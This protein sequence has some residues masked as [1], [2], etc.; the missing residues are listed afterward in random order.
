MKKLAKDNDE[1][2]Q[3][4]KDEAA[5]FLNETRYTV[6]AFRIK[7][8]A[9]ICET[10]GLKENAQS[11]YE[12]AAKTYRQAAEDYFTNKKS[13]RSAAE[14][15]YYALEIYTLLGFEEEIKN[16]Y[17][18][19][20]NS[21]QAAS[22]DYILWEDWDDAVASISL[23]ALIYILIE[24][25]ES[26]KKTFDDWISQTGYSSEQVGELPI[27]NLTREVIEA[28]ES[29]DLELLTKDRTVLG[30][31]LKSALVR[32]N[33]SFLNE[34]VDQAFDVLENK[35]REQVLYPNLESTIEFPFD[36]VYGDEFAIQLILK[37]VG[38]GNAFDVQLEFFPQKGIIADGDIVK[39]RN[40]IEPAEEVK[41]QWTLKSEQRERETTEFPI[42]INLRYMDSLKTIYSTNIG[43]FPLIIK[44]FSEKEKAKFLIDEIN[45]TLETAE[46]MIQRNVECSNFF[47][48]LLYETSRDMVK[49]AEKFR[50]EEFEKV[51]AYIYAAT[52]IIKH[53]NRLYSNPETKNLLKQFKELDEG[54]DIESLKELLL[55]ASNM[56]NRTIKILYSVKKSIKTT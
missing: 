27:L 23:S 29:L 13:Y 10:K 22:F 7:E 49:E 32:I 18:N 43:P 40:I 30:S 20:A 2:I 28:Y 1:L 14:N 21:L 42:S 11:L 52:E 19:V 50:E 38:E 51:N 34:L 48:Y 25:F 56:L 12:Q 53:L 8:A 44:K 17:T 15:F 26:G 6:A 41:F 4:L 46:E 16:C 37:N 45:S 31:I 9:K 5:E 33:A 24:D 54:K 3:R 55:K 47:P 36:V 39:R 35:I